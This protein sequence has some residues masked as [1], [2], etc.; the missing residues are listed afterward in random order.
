MSMS[1]KLGIE[2]VYRL[3]PADAR[4]AVKW[5][6]RSR[7]R[8][9]WGNLRRAHPFS[10]HYGYDRGVP[11]DRVF[12]ERFMETERSLVRGRVL[13]VKDTTYSQR[14]GTGVIS[15]DV[16][17]IDES[18]AA[19]TIVADL[20]Q[21]GSLAGRRFDCIVF[22]QVLQF[23]GN[24]RAALANLY[25]ALAPGG[26]LLITVPAGG[27]VMPLPEGPDHRRYLV[28]GLHWL[29]G[30][31]APDATVSVRAWGNLVAKT[32]DQYGLAAEELRAHELDATD[33]RFPVIISGVLTK[34]ST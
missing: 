29:L 21:P 25:D 22:T 26:S 7:R 32:A 33:A 16:V 3:L 34:P 1:S 5:A 14:F 2:S 28:P 13:E 8:A 27:R 30:D 18:N 31:E 10:D 23:I 19:A 17:D 6:N 4:R 20:G 12:I 15:T 24:D 11:I 9:R